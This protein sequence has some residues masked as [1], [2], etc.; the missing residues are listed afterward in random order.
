MESEKVQVHQ[1]ALKTKVGI[2]QSKQTPIS[3]TMN[4]R[5][6]PALRFLLFLLTLHTCCK[7]TVPSPAHAAPNIAHWPSSNLHSNERYNVASAWPPSL[8]HIDIWNAIHTPT[9]S[10]IP[11]EDLE[12]LSQQA[13]E[14]F[15]YAG[16]NYEAS[17]K[18]TPNTINDKQVEQKLNVKLKHGVTK[19]INEKNLEN[20]TIWE[21]PNDR[22]K[23]V[24]HLFPVPVDGECLSD[25]GRRIGNCFNIYE[26]RA[27]GGTAKGECAMGF[28]VC[29]IFIAS[30]NTTIS[31]NIT[32]LVSPQF[33]S[34][35]P[36]N[37]SAPCNFKIQLMS[38][39]VSQLRIDFYH[40]S[41]GQPNRRTGSCDG[42]VFAVNG[43]PSG[44]L[45]LCGQNSG[46]HIYYEVGGA[47]A[48]RQTLFGNLRPLTFSQ[49]YPNNSVSE[50]PII[51]I[52]MN[53]TQRFQPIRLWEIRIAQIPFSQRAPVGCL[54][55][56]TGTEGIIQTFNFAENG[57]HLANQNYRICMRQEQEMCS[58]MYQPCDEQSFRIG[59]SNAGEPGVVN[60]GAPVI[61][62]DP[63][64]SSIMSNMMG[65]ATNGGAGGGGGSSTIAGDNPT[66]DVMPTMQSTV[67]AD[68]PNVLQMMD[69]TTMMAATMTSATTSGATS[70]TTAAVTDSSAAASESSAATTTAATSASSASPASSTEVSSAA[71]SASETPAATSQAPASSSSA[72]TL[73]T[74]S[75][76]TPA[77]TSSSSTLSDE[78]PE[79]SG[80]G[81]AD[82]IAGAPT[83]RPGAS[84]GGFDLL[85][86]LRSAFDF[87]SF[88][89]QSRQIDERSVRAKVGI[90]IPA[91]RTRQ[92]YSRC[93]DRLTM[94]CIVEDFI[95]MGPLGSP[96]LPGCEPVHCGS[97]FCSSGIWPCR[98]ES[99]VTPFYVGVHFGNGAGKGSAE[100]NIGACLRFQQVECM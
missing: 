97:Q 46:Q 60:M 64:M 28:G 89:R 94:P 45:T 1:S 65:D 3:H 51:E 8:Q 86:F 9:N 40:F 25:D 21:T 70:A 17:F 15:Q 78:I 27:K 62:M 69:A 100:D 81:D 74:R 92:L 37:Y 72:T 2:S 58:I 77:T 34:F 50:M 44:T 48:P 76:T 87:N 98:I 13:N 84:S 35:M 57:R 36:S 39:E 10:A 90:D 20:N 38:N 18:A 85:G 96:T 41:V 30:C 71:T 56:H 32:Y 5:C 6:I 4:Y 63:M 49:L 7:Y 54:Q 29:C 11:E 68:D 55:Y 82:W 31:N 24:I 59:P 91:R 88:R 99:T 26:C 53:F 14:G 12:V 75:S 80:G 79:G 73:D 47:A 83:R 66:M 95:G 16:V 61:M 93:T 19:N 52:S 33:P 23:R 67:L 22:Q 43:G 42:D